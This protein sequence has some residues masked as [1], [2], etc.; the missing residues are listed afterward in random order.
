[1]HPAGGGNVTA[2]R[3]RVATL[4]AAA[5]A[6]VPADAPRIDPGPVSAGIDV[7]RDETFARLRGARL[8]L[9][10]NQTGRALD[11]VSTIDL[12]HE[13]PAV[14]LK[15]LF[16]PEHGIRGTFDAAVPV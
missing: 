11:G 2:L 8:G 13:T 6:G 14:Q 16:S 4:A 1:M 3:G 9:L 7:L 15:T 5:I 12:L 10:T